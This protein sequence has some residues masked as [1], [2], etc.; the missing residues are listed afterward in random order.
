MIDSRPT[1]G[2]TQRGMAVATRVTSETSRKWKPGRHLTEG[3]HDD[4]DDRTDEGVADEERPG[5]GVGQSLTRSNNETSSKG[6][7]DGYSCQLATEDR[8]NEL[9]VQ[10]VLTNHSNVTRLQATMKAS[11]LGRLEATNMRAIIVVTKLLR[12]PVLL[13]LVLAG[14]RVLLAR[15]VGAPIMEAVFAGIHV[16][17]GKW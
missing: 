13:S 6:T 16:A 3:R 12:V 14:T 4:E 15:G 11:A 9:P 17:R 8:Q 2:K 7:T 1:E 5:P 10:R